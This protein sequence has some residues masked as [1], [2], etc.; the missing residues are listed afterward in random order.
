MIGTA[1]NS[2]DLRARRYE[3]MPVQYEI[4]KKERIPENNPVRNII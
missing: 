3:Y 4:T 2:I 1:L